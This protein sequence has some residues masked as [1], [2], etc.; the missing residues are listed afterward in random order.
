[1]TALPSSMQ[2][3]Q[4]QPFCQF[5]IKYPQ[6]SRL[7]PYLRALP[8]PDAKPWKPPHYVTFLFCTGSY[9][10]I[11]YLSLTVF[12]LHVFPKHIKRYMMKLKVMSGGTRGPSNMCS[13]RKKWIYHSFV[14]KFEPPNDTEWWKLQEGHLEL[15]E[16][17]TLPGGRGFGSCE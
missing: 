3:E 2:L 6:V 12:F 10:C 8:Q 9:L 5:G 16:A 1:M 11:F 4:T 13:F 7:P 17:T 15:S 14:F